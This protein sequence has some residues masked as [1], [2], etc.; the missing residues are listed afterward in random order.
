MG[1]SSE[2]FTAPSADC[3]D[4]TVIFEGATST[5]EVCVA[6]GGWYFFW[7]LQFLRRTLPSSVR[8]AYDRTST[9]SSTSALFHFRA[10]GLGSI[11]A[12]SPLRKGDSSRVLLL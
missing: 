2:S 9:W 7:C 11:T 4:V 6:G 1:G 12:A 5:S 8:T 10:W 3:V